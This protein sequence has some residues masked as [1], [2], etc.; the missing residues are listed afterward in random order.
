M[1]EPGFT[2]LIKNCTCLLSMDRARPVLDG[3][4]VLVRDHRIAQV[5]DA[6]E[7]PPS[8]D[9]VI[10]AGGHVV[11]PGLVNTHHHLFQTL[12]RVVPSVQDAELFSWL[13]DLY[14]FMGSLTDEMLYY[15]CLVG[16]AELMLSG[17]TTAQDHFYLSVNDTSFDT[18][19]QAA[20][21]AGIRFHLSRGSF[22]VGQSLGGLPPDDTVEDEDAIL[23]DCQR[24]VESYHDPQ[25][26][27]ML[28]IELAP[29]S[30]FSVSERLMQESAV[31][32]RHYR[33][34]LHTHLCET[35]DE[36]SFCLE[37]YGRRPVQLA[38]DLGWTGPDVWYAHAVHMNSD[39]VGLLAR[40][41]TGVAHCP[42][43]NMRLGS[44]IAPIC[45]MLGKGV[46]V[47]LG[48]DGSASNDS[49][50]LLAEARMAML[51]Q[52]VKHGA[53]AMTASQALE[54]ATLGGARVL[55]R[56]DI[57]AL[58]PGMAADIAGFDLRQLGYAGSVHDP[59]AA[60]VF[61]NPGAASFLMINGRMVVEHGEIAG[62]D[63]P[64]V[65]ARH[66]QLAQELMARTEARFGH[67][68]ATRV[69]RWTSHDD[70]PSWSR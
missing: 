41:G 5:G 28:R 56:S 40:T 30:P 14:L 70:S 64:H 23:A 26:G 3:G 42:S 7:P 57:G 58:R 4:W 47:G 32:A 27:A 38:Q 68:L 12:L 46:P 22:S 19:I 54:L 25:P 53:R 20:R 49:S 10:D 17:C 9:T 21:A 31:M 16:L 35:S 39:E 1:N 66:N 48:V 52:R 55:Q 60:L 45:E 24:L 50:H 59:A 65:I 6:A 11:L 61:C 18:E 44:G 13:K 63:L 37:H 51:L 2:T 43:S 8:A 67:R 36:E 33:V 69:W 62:L 29:C 34:G 15:S